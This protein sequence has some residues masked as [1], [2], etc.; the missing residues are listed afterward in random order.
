M[1]EKA[2]RD[3]LEEAQGR[4]A[5][6]E[7][8]RAVWLSAIQMAE[9]WLRIYGAKD[10]NGASQSALPG[11]SKPARKRARSASGMS[12]RGAVAHVLREA[13]GAPLHREEILKRI[14]VLGA[15]TNAK[16]AP[17]IID[18]VAIN[19]KTRSDMPIEKVSPRTWRWTGEVDSNGA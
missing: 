9:G 6:I 18:L 2:A 14:R 16:D 5:K 4:L 12:L 1:N 17:G 19:L 10:S 3:L 15:D 13:R 8:E 7:E 11:I